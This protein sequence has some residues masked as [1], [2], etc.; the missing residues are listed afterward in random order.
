M[1]PIDANGWMVP[2]RGTKAR[3]VYAL[4][5]Y[6]LKPRQIMKHLPGTSINCIRVMAWKIRKPK[7]KRRQSI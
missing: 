5:T 7:A 4:M 2:K 6:G 3:E 1:N